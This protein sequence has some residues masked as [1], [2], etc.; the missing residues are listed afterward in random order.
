M[1]PVSEGRASWSKGCLIAIAVALGLV[2]VCGGIVTWAGYSV[3]KNPQ[4][5]RAVAIGGAAME[6]TQESMHAPGTTEMRAVGCTQAMG[7]TPELMQRFIGAIAPD[8]GV[9]APAI[10]LAI[11]A[12][13][14]GATLV[15]SCEDAVRAYAGAQSP[16]QTEI[17]AR[18]TVQGEQVARCEGVYT[19]DGT[20]LREMDAEMARTFGRMGTS[21]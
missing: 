19:P 8:A 6:L 11:C 1:R 10:P 13:Q 5:Q 3:W 16:A 2:L 4:V 14:R 21:P 15:P 9:E 12:M 18:V 20:F 17:A 7:F